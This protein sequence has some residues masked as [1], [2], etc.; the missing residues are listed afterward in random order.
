MKCRDQLYELVKE[1]IEKK[2]SSTKE[3]QITMERSFNRMDNEVIAWNEAFCAPRNIDLKDLKAKAKKREDEMYRLQKSLE[4]RNGLL[5]PSASTIGKVAIMKHVHHPNVVLFMGAVTQRPHLSIVTEYLPR[6]SLYRLI[7]RADAGEVLDQRRCLRMAL[8]VAKGINYLHC[9]SPLVVH[10]DL[11]SPNLLVDK[12]WTVC[13]FGLSRFKA[14]TFISS[15]SVA[16]TELKDFAKSQGAVESE[17]LTHWDINFWS[18]RLRE[19][20]YNLNEKQREMTESETG[21]IPRKA[22]K[23]TFETATYMPS[24]CLHAILVLPL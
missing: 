12:N 3:W 17:E 9:L 16:G 23:V 24:M 19:S 21:Q 10:W 8:D 22:D 6:G 18:G 13:D 2:D 14:N 4:E 7:H 1:K 20:S 11:K 15:K 5:Q